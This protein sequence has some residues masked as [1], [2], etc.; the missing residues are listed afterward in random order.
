MPEKIT[1]DD[2]AA[3]ADGR[4]LG[5]EDDAWWRFGRVALESCES[6]CWDLIRARENI[7]GYVQTMMLCG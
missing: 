6:F 5:G 4:L 1:L 3:A 2:A 7:L